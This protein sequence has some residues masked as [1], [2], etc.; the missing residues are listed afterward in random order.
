[1]TPRDKASTDAS[2][3]GGSGA[4]RARRSSAAAVTSSGGSGGG[5]GGLEESKA[6][7]AEL[8]ALGLSAKGSKAELRV[9]LEEAKKKSR[10]M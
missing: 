9:R 7:K 4:D 2:A 10:G 6:L 3:A 5:G 8:K 1:V